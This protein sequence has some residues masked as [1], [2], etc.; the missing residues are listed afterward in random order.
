M[1]QQNRHSKERSPYPD[2]ISIHKIVICNLLLY[3]TILSDRLCTIHEAIALVNRKS[4][5]LVS[6]Y[7]ERDYLITKILLL[8]SCMISFYLQLSESFNFVINKNIY[9]PYIASHASN[10]LCIPCIFTIQ[11]VIKRD[12]E[13]SSKSI[14]IITS[15]LWKQM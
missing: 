9:R 4:I 13:I 5:Y 14:K 8:R 10:Y 6:R 12:R 1:L 7:M 15:I 3:Y 2:Y 11:V